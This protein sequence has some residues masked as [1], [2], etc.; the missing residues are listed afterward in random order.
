MK[1]T[2]QL[3]I[4]ITIKERLKKLS[5]Q[6]GIPIARII[7]NILQGHLTEEELKYGIQLNVNDKH[8]VPFKTKKN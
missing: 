8:H 7:Q 5:D 2:L 6:T 1:T 4:D 3:S